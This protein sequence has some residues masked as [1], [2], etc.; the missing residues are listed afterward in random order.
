MIGTDQ[1]P[2]NMRHDQADKTDC[3]GNGYADTDQYGYRN[4]DNQ[5]YPLHIDADM[6]GVILANGE[7]IQFRTEADENSAAGQE[8]D[9]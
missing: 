3:A 5:L 8:C 9:A 4:Q 1:H 6:P 2:G 7:S